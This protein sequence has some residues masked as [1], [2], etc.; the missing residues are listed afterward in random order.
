MSATSIQRFSHIV[1][2]P[3]GM[4]ARWTGEIAIISLI[5]IS[6]IAPPVVLSGSLPWVKAEHLM[7]PVVFAVYGWLLLAGHVRTIRLN[8]MFPIAAIMC[9]SIAISIWYGSSILGQTV[10]LRD[11]YDIP[12]A[13]LP[14]IFFTIAY[15]AE[16][17]EES[18]RRLLSYLAAT[19]FL[20]CA[21][22]WAQFADLGPTHFL[23]QFYS[24]G[25]HIDGGLQRY[26]RV[27][28]TMGNANVLG[29]LMS[30]SVVTFTMAALF[31]V[32][33]RIRNIALAFACVVTVAMTASRYGLL[34]TC[35]G[36]VM[37]FLI[38]SSPVI[39]RVKR[40]GLLLLI[41]PIFAWAALAVATTFTSTVDR[42]EALQHPLEVKSLRQRTEGLWRDAGN[43]IVESPFVGHGPAKTI[44]T[45][46][47]T[48][49]EYL[50]ILKEEGILG[51]MPY[52]AY[53]LFPLYLIWK[54]LR[55]AGKLAAYEDAIPATFLTLRLSF[56]FVVTA[57][58]MN[59]GMTTFHNLIL[60]A[61][62]WLWLGLGARS[63]KFFMESTPA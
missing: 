4:L 13:C 33:S 16:L 55:A 22:G 3:G 31:R 9:F 44:F 51:L 6:I 7:L 38:P 27:Y 14:A 15:E 28:S 54:G 41:L 32:G 1:Y 46:I 8:G 23:N 35:F 62:L 34:T 59:I 57:L 2:G 45:G 63:A 40:A 60:Q 20:I 48:D 24:G 61:F 26:H 50:D 30:W 12:K 17:S 42:F 36:I 56:V 52:L 58:L 39:Q 11:F 5:C 43:D 25:E 37:V 29:Q 10:I 49:S 21:Y 47:W 19:V 18:L 53:Y